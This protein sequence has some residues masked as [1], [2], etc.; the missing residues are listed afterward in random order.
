[1][2]GMLQS[3]LQL[4]LQPQ[5]LTVRVNKTDIAVN[6]NALVDLGGLHG[7]QGYKVCWTAV[8]PGVFWAVRG[9]HKI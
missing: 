7:L 2:D 8:R 9:Q 5:E 6:C 1:M 3:A 4:D